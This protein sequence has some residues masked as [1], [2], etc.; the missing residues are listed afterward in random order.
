MYICRRL[1]Q[2]PLTNLYQHRKL[3]KVGGAVD[4]I[5][6]VVGPHLLFNDAMLSF[7]LGKEF[8]CYSDMNSK[9]IATCIRL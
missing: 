7:V 1:W 2:L 8:L 9:S 6:E 3:L 5:T 4:V